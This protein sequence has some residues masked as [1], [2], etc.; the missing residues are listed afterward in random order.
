MTP[1]AGGPA[2]GMIMAWQPEGYPEREIGWALFTDAA[3]GQGFAE[4]GAR[5]VLAHVFRVL[6]WGTAVSYIAPR[7]ASSIRMA[8]RLGAMH[9]PAAPQSDPDDPDMIWRHNRGMWL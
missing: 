6:G 3:A 9:D 4:E 2:L 5:A 8:K 7:N 1:K